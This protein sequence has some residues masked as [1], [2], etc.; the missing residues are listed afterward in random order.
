MARLTM[1]GDAFEAYRRDSFDAFKKHWSSASL[2][3]T[4]WPRGMEEAQATDLLSS[5]HS[6]VFLSR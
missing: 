2:W 1:D 4:A 6:E 5:F 3:Q